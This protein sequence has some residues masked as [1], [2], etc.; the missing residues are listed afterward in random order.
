MMFPSADPFAYPNQP[1]TTLEN[2]HFT[3]DT[4]HTSVSFAT[5]YSTNHINSSSNGGATTNFS[6]SNGHDD[7]K[8]HPLSFTTSPSAPDSQSFFPPTS[9]SQQSHPPQSA[10]FDNSLEAQLF[11]PMPPYLIHG[12]QMD[13]ALDNT[14]LL[15]GD[16]PNG[17]C[18]SSDAGFGRG[19]V[20]SS[21]ADADLGVDAA[22]PLDVGMS[23]LPDGWPANVGNAANGMAV[24]PVDLEAV[25]GEEWQENWFDGAFGTV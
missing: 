5:A 25:F 7:H 20:S 17:A 8:K 1:M 23:L 22:Q 21:V 9:S 4:P 16:A 12:H 18:M 19:D 2:D 13:F 11:G 10:P 24:E 3:A 15:D 6:N 14:Q